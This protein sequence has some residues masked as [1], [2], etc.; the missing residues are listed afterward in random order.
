MEGSVDDRY[1]DSFGKKLTVADLRV[2]STGPYRSVWINGKHCCLGIIVSLGCMY[3]WGLTLMV[4]QR[5]ETK[6][7]CMLALL[8]PQH[9]VLLIQRD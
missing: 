1:Y 5:K 4:R 8:S 2:S 7:T 3:R 6:G 9:A